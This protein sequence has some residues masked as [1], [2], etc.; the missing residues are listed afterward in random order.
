MA[1][2][3]RQIL[4]IEESLLKQAAG[5]VTTYSW[6][7]DY[8]VKPIDEIR[9]AEYRIGALDNDELV[10]F[11][12][13]G[14]TF[15]PEGKDNNQLWIGHAVVL[16]SYRRK[17]VFTLIYKEQMTYCNKIGGSIFTCS[18]NPVVTTFLIKERWQKVRETSDESGKKTTIFKHGTTQ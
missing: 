1:I 13:V 5:L 18:D 16:P 8:P 10:G 4:A 9:A 6:G 14:R 2:H 7:K 11:G 17:G 3:L 15:S 12:A